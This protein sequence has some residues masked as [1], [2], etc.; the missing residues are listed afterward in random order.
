MIS[1]IKDTKSIVTSK[2]LNKRP[3]RRHTSDQAVTLSVVLKRMEK[4]HSSISKIMN[5]LISKIS[6]FKLHHMDRESNNFHKHKLSPCSN[7]TQLSMP[8]TRDPY[9]QEALELKV[10]I[11]FS[12]RKPR[13][14]KMPPRTILNIKG[15][16]SK[17]AL[18]EL[19]INHLK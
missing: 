9:F 18:L 5:C 10:G 2:E 1:I 6:C 3:S 19:Q 15:I 11:G 7:R 17:W 13:E 16:C 14:N 8:L 12:S 4:S